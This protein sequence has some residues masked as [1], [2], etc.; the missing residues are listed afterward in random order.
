ME[1]CPYATR[2]FNQLGEIVYLA[3]GSWNC[4]RCALVN[5]LH[6]A[7]RVR[8]GVALWRPRPAYFWTLTLPGWVETAWLGYQILPAAWNRFQCR[9]RRRCPDWY[10]AAFTEGHPYR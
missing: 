2:A 7:E 8:Y 5:S 10:Y 1:T 9:V 6:W 4:P 3:C